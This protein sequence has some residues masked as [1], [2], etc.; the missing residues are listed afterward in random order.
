MKK[1]LNKLDTIEWIQA[2]GSFFIGYWLIIG[3]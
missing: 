2:A 1:I 3:W